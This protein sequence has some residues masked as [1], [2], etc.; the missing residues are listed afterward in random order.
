MTIRHSVTRIFKAKLM[1]FTPKR[2]VKLSKNQAFLNLSLITESALWQVDVLV[3]FY[4][5]YL[6]Y[7]GK[8]DC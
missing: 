6:H 8:E 7:N 2:L 5:A 3:D 4:N 1:F